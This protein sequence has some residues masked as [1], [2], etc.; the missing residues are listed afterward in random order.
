MTALI[1]TYSLK[2]FSSTV[3]HWDHCVLQEHCL[4]TFL[5]CSLLWYAV[6]KTINTLKNISLKKKKRGCPPSTG[7]YSNPITTYFQI[8]VKEGSWIHYEYNYIQHK[9][10]FLKHDCI[11]APRLFKMHRHVWKQLWLTR[12][13]VPQ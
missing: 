4:K 9:S 13:F 3:L 7:L 12:H 11:N 5:P 8:T 6:G 10:V 1:E 2:Q